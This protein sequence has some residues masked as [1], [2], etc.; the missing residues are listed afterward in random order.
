MRSLL[1]SAVRGKSRWLVIKTPPPACPQAKRPAQLPH[2][3]EEAQFGA[4]AAEL[5]L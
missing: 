5:F 2:R 4:A 1:A 3:A